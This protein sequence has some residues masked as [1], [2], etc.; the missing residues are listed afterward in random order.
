MNM[1]GWWM[2]VL[3]GMCF[4]TV[5]SSMAEGPQKAAEALS[6]GVQLR[7][8][9]DIEGAIREYSEALRLDPKY[10]EA[11]CMR[12]IAYKSKGDFDKAIADQTEAI[13]LNLKFAEAYCMRGVAQKSKGKLN[14]S[15]DDFTQAIRL[16]PKY[17]EAYL[18]RGI[19]N[20]DNGHI[21]AAI[22]D[23]SKAI[24]LDSTDAGAYCMRGIARKQKGDIDKAVSDFTEAI[25]LDPKYAHAY[26]NRG[27]A[28]SQKGDEAK[29]EADFAEAKKFGYALPSESGPQTK[30]APALLRRL[31]QNPVKSPDAA[32]WFAGLSIEKKRTYAAQIGHIVLEGD[33]GGKHENFVVAFGADQ[34]P[35]PWAFIVGKD[36][37]ELCEGN[38]FEYVRRD[39]ERGKN[40]WGVYWVVSQRYDTKVATGRVVFQKR[41]KQKGTA[42]CDVWTPAAGWQ[43]VGPQLPKSDRVLRA[44]PAS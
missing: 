18:L 20:D 8:M 29:A 16:N 22:S 10:A 39:D 15:I 19:A 13:R 38:T 21:D 4:L 5:R 1:R 27:W 30:E 33:K 11:Y 3:A 23:Y 37:L 9:G 40:Q 36:R 24:R 31:K 43:Y 6:R 35:Y 12:G 17:T 42:G 41:P 28:Y 14:K 25:R 26:A 7:Q 34:S 44:S 2:A 32:A